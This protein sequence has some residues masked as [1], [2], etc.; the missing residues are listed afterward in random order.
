MESRPA[1]GV[2][3]ILIGLWLAAQ[4][5]GG[6]IGGRIRAAAGPKLGKGSPSA[7]VT[8][9]KIVELMKDSKKRSAP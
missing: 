5:I 6:D 1:S 7:E 4:G 2:A 8:S 3:M 9:P